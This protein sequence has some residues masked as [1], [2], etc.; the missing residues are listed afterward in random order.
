MI[1]KSK[2]INQSWNFHLDKVSTYAYWEKAFTP[3]ECEKIIKIAKHKGLVKGTTKDNKD[4]RE[5]K[6]SL[7]LEE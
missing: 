5:S 1:K 6:V 3:E 2:F 4:V 7:H